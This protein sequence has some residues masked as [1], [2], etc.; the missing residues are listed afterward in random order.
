MF[1]TALVPWILK[2]PWGMMTIKSSVFYRVVGF[3]NVVHLKRA[4]QVFSM[5]TQQKP[6]CQNLHSPN[7]G[8][9]MLLFPRIGLCGAHLFLRWLWRGISPRSSSE[10]FDKVS[11]NCSQAWKPFSGY[12]LSAQE[13][14]LLQKETLCRGQGNTMLEYKRGGGHAS[15]GF[16][17]AFETLGYRFGTSMILTQARVWNELCVH[18]RGVR[19]VMCCK[20]V[21]H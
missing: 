4:R 19:V 18:V 3:K 15:L 9:T 11:A 14:N 20:C 10:V 12:L 21:V 17:T 8:R 16:N 2:C 1:N 6:L 7:T 5:T 13:V